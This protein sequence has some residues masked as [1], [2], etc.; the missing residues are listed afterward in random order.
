MVTRIARRFI[1]VH[2]T[3]RTGK[4]QLARIILPWI[5]GR[6]TG[7]TIHVAY[8]SIGNR[9]GYEQDKERAF[10]NALAEALGDNFA[11]NYDDA[12]GDFQ[13]KCKKLLL[14]HMIPKS[15]LVVVF[16][17]VQNLLGGLAD[18]D[19]LPSMLKAVLDIGS[20]RFIPIVT[21]STGAC[22]HQLLDETTPM[23]ALSMKEQLSS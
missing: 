15:H 17:E 22:V 7:V 5:L 4:T 11:L 19:I 6:Q 21:G 3:P 14:L 1:M 16:D 10:F 9:I 2:G 12:E 18:R 23:V 13:M 20:T 8:L